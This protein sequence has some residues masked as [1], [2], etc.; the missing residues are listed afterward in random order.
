MKSEL[1]EKLVFHK[2]GSLW[3]KGHEILGVQEGYWEWYR[4]NGVISRSGHFV[5]GVQVGEWTTYDKEGNVYKVTKIKAKK[6]T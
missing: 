1:V 4:K 3:A 2:D 6:N 5:G